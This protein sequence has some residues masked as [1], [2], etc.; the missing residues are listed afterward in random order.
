MRSS[1][2][3]VLLLALGVSLALAC[4]RTTPRAQGDGAT[5]IGGGAG[6]GPAREPPRF[7]AAGALGLFGHPPDPS[8]ADADMEAMQAVGANSVVLPVFWLAHD[9]TSTAIEPLPYGVP[10]EAYDAAA[11]EIARRAHARGLAFELLPILKLERL[12]PGHWRGT[13]APKDWSAWWAAYRSF[14]LHHARVAE[15]CRAEI[16]VVGS[17]L[18]TTEAQRDLWSALI[19][20]VR[21]IFHGALLYSANWDH[22]EAV[23]FWDL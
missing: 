14:I 11:V 16:F 1:K 19:Q 3:V 15:A 4:S 18:G 5:G 2:I 22:Y 6:H 10:Q 7:F 9:D 21:S 12:E 8:D 17:E 20:E 23:V 13:L